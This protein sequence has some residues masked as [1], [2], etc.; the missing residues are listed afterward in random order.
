M[1]DSNKQNTNTRLK[2]FSFFSLLFYKQ[3]NSEQDPKY[4]GDV[5]KQCLPSKKY[6]KESAASYRMIET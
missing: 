2:S 3:I 4:R 5:S 1:V 6:M